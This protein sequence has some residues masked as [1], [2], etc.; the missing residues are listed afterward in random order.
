MAHG[1]HASA[2]RYPPDV[3][4]PTYPP[5]GYPEE[6]WP[7]PESVVLRENVPVAGAPWL[8]VDV[9]HPR[10]AGEPL[11]VVIWVHGGGWR[12]GSRRA[13]MERLFTFVQA[14]FVAIPMDYRLTDVAI[15][16]AQLDDVR[17]VVRWVGR[18]AEWLQVDPQRITL[19]G[20]SSGGHLALLAG[21]TGT[22]NV[23]AVIAVSA[24]TDLL[25]MDDY[26][27]GVEGLIEHSSAESFEGLLLGGAPLE[28][29]EL[30]LRASPITHVHAGAPPVLLIHG[31]AD[32]IVPVG[33]SRALARALSDVGTDVTYREYG[34]GE[35]S[36]RHFPAGWVEDAGEWL[37]SRLPR[38]RA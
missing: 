15:Y 6:G 1:A 5:L 28:Q 27:P 24:P 8:H 10:D 11:P 17:T 25:S 3:E 13:A 30:A 31:D 21:L 32:R 4:L 35:H 34:G 14:G 26:P 29:R 38:P 20:G 23:V 9:L 18:D 7:K 16:P 12:R 2:L 37:Q 22:E 33:Q 36:A 19:F